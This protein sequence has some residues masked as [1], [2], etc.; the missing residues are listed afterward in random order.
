MNRCSPN[1]SSR[2]GTSHAA[3][4]IAE[5]GS[6]R[7]SSSRRPACIPGHTSVCIPGRTSVCIPERTSACTRGRKSAYTHGRKSACTP[8]RSNRDERVPG[9]VPG[10]HGRSHRSHLRNRRNTSS[11][12][13]ADRPWLQEVPADRRLRARPSLPTRTQRSREIPPFGNSTSAQGRRP[14]R[15]ATSSHGLPAG[16]RLPYVT[17]FVCF[18]Q[19][20]SSS[21]QT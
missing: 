11:S 20:Q 6:S 8:T 19:M 1:R 16:P 4:R 15:P 14:Q 17:Q 5:A 18:Q 9:I 2:D 13:P 21:W 12:R 3:A 7:S 10:T